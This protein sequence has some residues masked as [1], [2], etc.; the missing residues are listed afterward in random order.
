M[1]T[2]SNQ[3]IVIDGLP[4]N[5]EKLIVKWYCGVKSNHNAPSEAKVTICFHDGI[6]AHGISFYDIGITHLGQFPIGSVWQRKRLVK[7]EPDFVE[8]VFTISGQD[9]AWD[10]VNTWASDSNGK[11]LIPK[12][13]YALPDKENCAP[14]KMVRFTIDGDTNALIIPCLELFARLYGRSQH[15]KKSLLNYP[16]SMAEENLLYPDVIPQAQGTWLVTV[17]KH[18]VNEDA[19]FL[20]HLKHDVV[21]KKRTSIIWSS[22]QSK[23]E[24]SHDKIG[25]PSVPPWFSDTVQIKVKGIWLDNKKT[26]F[27]GLQILGCSDPIG[28]EIHLDRENTNLSESTSDGGG[29]SVINRQTTT[30]TGTIILTS[31]HEPGRNQEPVQVFNPDFEIIGDQREITRV[32][33]EQK[34]TGQLFVKKVDEK[35]TSHSGG[36][37]YGSKLNIKLVSFDTPLIQIPPT[38]MNVW[39]ALNKLV[40]SQAL[41]SV[42]C[43]DINGQPIDSDEAPVLIS[44]PKEGLNR[45]LYNWVMLDDS[46]NPGKKKNRRVLL[47]KLN[48]QRGECYLMEIERRISR[49]GDNAGG[50]SDS[51]KGLVVKFP[52]GHFQSSWFQKLLVEIIKSKGVVDK[53]LEA[54]DSSV[55]TATFKHVGEDKENMEKA[56]RNGLK[57]IDFL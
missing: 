40:S 57:K 26:R 28:P 27:L 16:L 48:N 39:H 15:V 21:T 34:E 46:N 44:L 1:S 37:E 7:N 52:Q 23:H 49:R 17:T 56:V 29:T 20:A 22:L 38:F 30:Q 18:C 33:R 13:L 31:E 47:N 42:S 53:A 10:I 43:I 9:G 25:F 19:V 45:E 14:A 41:Q 51:F 24:N 6:S 3:A 55:I 8:Q 36:D 50:E 2:N 11:P 32:V 4:D 5:N 35:V 12:W 54:C